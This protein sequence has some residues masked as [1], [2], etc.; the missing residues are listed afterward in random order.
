MEPPPERK[1]VLIFEP[2]VEGHHMFMLRFLTEDFLGA[3]LSVTL[4]LD[5]RPEPSKRIESQMSDLLPRV[6]VI[7]AVPDSPGQIKTCPPARVA[8]CLK[9][10][11][12]DLVFMAQF[13][14]LASA[15]LRR[16][17]F[18]MMPDASM[19][20]R[21]G[22]IYFRPQFLSS[23]SLSPNVIL[24]KIGFGRLVKGGWL[25][26]LLML[27][28]QPCAAAQKKYPGAPIY[29]LADPYPE[30]F[31]AD[32]AASRARFHL[33][34]DRFVFLFYGGAY[35]R[36]GLHLAA[37]AM[38]NMTGA[39]HAFLLCAGLQSRDEKLARALA[40]LEAAGRA[41]IINRYV[42]DDEE[43]QLFAACDAVLLPYLRHP[44]ASG[45]LSRAA[46][47]GKPVV[48]SDE[49]LLGHVLRQYGMGLLFPS[50]NVAELQKAMIRAAS[51][52]R[53]QLSEWEAGARSY[54][55]TC[56]RDVYRTVLVTAVKNAL[57]AQ[58]GDRKFQPA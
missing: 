28:P 18:G 43:K 42:T 27:D 20:A 30:D 37:A 6:R 49:Y 36:K 29:L 11:G 3:G 48:A 50:G 1:H 55:Q 41:K 21:L 13:N 35:R 46:G 54:A 34:E 19:R 58:N 44:V 26:P 33:P 53:E 12:A 10:S 7:P 52:G 24:K 40:K 16:A 51:A 32:R 15:M 38:E 57:Q 2:H 39:N 22:G 31:F 9:Q 25:N 56:S 8:A 5:T 23:R 47:A 14:D 17:A 4:A 45:V